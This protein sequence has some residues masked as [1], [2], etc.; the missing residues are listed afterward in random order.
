VPPAR[1]VPCT[2]RILI[3][4]D[5]RH[6][7]SGLAA[8]LRASLPAPDIREAVS[9][10]EAVRLVDELAP[11]VILM[12]VRMSGMDGLAATRLIKERHPGTRII[13]LSLSAACAKEALAAGADA[14]V[15][16]G[17]NPDRLLALLAQ[18]GGPP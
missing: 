14:F 6:A 13:A 16:K 12:D 15:G 2:V 5:Q 17:E 1:G 8:L 3:A 10:S 4:D 18:P 11:D 9:G 7:R